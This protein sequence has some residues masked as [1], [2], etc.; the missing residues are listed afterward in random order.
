[1][2]LL[3]A[4]RDPVACLFVVPL[5][6]VF[7]HSAAITSAASCAFS[8]CS[9]VADV[10]I[11]FVL[12]TSCAPAGF[13][14]ISSA[15]DCEW[16]FSGVPL[17]EETARSSTPCILWS[18][19]FFFGFCDLGVCTVFA[20]LFRARYSATPNPHNRSFVPCTEFEMFDNVR[21]MGSVGAREAIRL[22]RYYCRAQ[23]CQKRL[24]SCVC[25]SHPVRL[26]RFV[27][28][29]SHTGRERYSRPFDAARSTS[30]TV[31]AQRCGLWMV[32][33]ALMVDGANSV[34]CSNAGFHSI[35][36][37]GVRPAEFTACSRLH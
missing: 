34:R 28:F 6:F 26:F 17:A 27:F 14:F 32:T 22:Q 31:S 4:H 12:P 33:L 23:L 8:F 5:E 13:C 21:T 9:C 25:S 16:C 2:I 7:S 37:D 24:V 3:N 10:T 15:F 30:R 35:D 1:M 19:G 11:A 20:P 18:W 36:D 29:G